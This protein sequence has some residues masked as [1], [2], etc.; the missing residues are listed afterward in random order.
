MIEKDIWRKAW[1]LLSA[2]EKRSALW[3]L[4]VIILGA[5]FSMVMVGSIM[6]FLAVLSDPERIRTIPV[7]SWA[8]TRFGFA[9]DYAFL[10]ALG[11]GTI[12]VLLISTAIQIL[13]NYVVEHFV[14]MRGYSIGLRLMTAYL[15]QPYVFFLNR[16]SGDMNTRL[17]SEAGKVVAGFLKPSADLVTGVLTSLLIVGLLLWVN[18]QI[19]LIAFAVL[20][21]AYGS[22]FILL[23]PRLRKLGAIRLKSNRTRFRLS[24]EAFSG[25]K[26]LKITGREGDYLTR[27]DAAA[28]Q[29]ARAS[30]LARVLSNV[31][32]Y[33]LQAVAF[34]GILLLC[35]LLLSPQGLASGQGLADLIPLL[36]V[37]A[38]AGQRLMPEMAKVYGSLAAL[39]TGMHAVQ[40]VHE[41]MIMAPPAAQDNTT[42]V[43]SQTLPMQRGV[44]LEQV[45]FRYPNA[46]RPGLEE[47]NLEIRPGEKI[48]IVGGT[49]AGKTTLADIILG[50]LEPMTGRILVDGKAITA[51]TH[52]AWQRM[53]GYVP[54]DIFLIDASV[55]QNIAFGIPPGQ[56]DHDAVQRAARIA[57]IDTLVREEL[58]QGYETLIGERGVRLSGGQRQRLGIARALY[59]NPTL[60]V[61]DEATSALDNLTEAEVMEAIEALPGDKTVV[62]I[63]H[64]LSTVRKCDRIVVMEKGRISGIGSWGELMAEN[65]HFRQMAE[66]VEPQTQAG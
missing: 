63:A 32:Q 33:L 5:M 54:Q 4:G 62:M 14:Q 19:T 48:A 35:L 40:A 28:L 12:L 46:E 22:I 49:G 20:G 1:A 59:H 21:G 56:I 57:Q 8:Y 64:R 44:A 25:I 34:S 29:M 37:F 18:W 47:I 23:R 52:R 2:Q 58:P 36:G 3:A 27:F 38:F 65:V 16:H 51:E 10:V 55:A 11:L 7:L 15:R 13:R 50:L 60:I 24:G 6:P 39:Q 45:S 26:D 41:D 17:L 30:I 31:P 42:D 53:I 66:L 9:S 61:F 43:S